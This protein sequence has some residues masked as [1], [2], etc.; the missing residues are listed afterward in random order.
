MRRPFYLL[1]VALMAACAG[2]GVRP[3]DYAATAPS[4]G[5]AAPSITAAPLAEEVAYLPA[6]PHPPPQRLT[7]A[8]TGDLLSHGPVY[9]RARSF[10]HDGLTYDYRP[11]FRLIAP[12]LQAADLA[13]CHLETPLSPDN[14]RLSGFPLFNAPG[15]LA[16]AIA[17]SGWDGCST[18]SNH[19]FDQGPVG[20]RLTLDALDSA[21][22]GHAGMARDE[23]E[24][25]APTFYRVGAATVAHLSFTYGLNGLALPE[26][27]PWLVDVTD[28]DLIIERAAWARRS[29]ADLVVL[30]IQWGEEYRVD[31]TPDQVA[32]AGRLMASPDID[33]IIGSHVHVVQPIDVVNGK[34]VIY[35]LGNFL[36]NQSANCCPARSQ[37]GMIVTMTAEGN[38]ADGYR[39][40]GVHVTPTRVDRTDFT[41]VPF[42]A[43]PP[44]VTV[45]AG[46]A[47][48]LRAASDDTMEI[49]RR[50][51][52]EVT[53][54]P[55]L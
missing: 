48:E 6:V 7:L 12:Y 18:A 27:Q 38:A 46:R 52:V 5:T 41:I 28:P 25:G 50:L 30:S 22:V 45:D 36:S 20:V 3:A 14:S 47:T 49:V 29:G 42:D 44:A 2:A 43:I 54:G 21:G 40:I 26:A 31:P 34:Y 39:F 19:S 35:G 13:I 33:L 4:V 9:R 23:A 51:G 8:F 32:L 15:D 55:R 1:T 24:A 53:A 10:G 17:E 16:R 11:M 37:N